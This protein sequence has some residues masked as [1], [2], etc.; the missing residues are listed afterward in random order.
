MVITQ[1]YSEIYKIVKTLQPIKCLSFENIHCVIRL[2]IL[3][4]NLWLSPY[5]AWKWRTICDRKIH[6]DCTRCSNLTTD[7]S[8]RNKNHSRKPS[9]PSKWHHF[10]RCSYIKPIA[11]RSYLF[12]D[13][14]QHSKVDIRKY[15]YSTAPRSFQITTSQFIARSI[16]QNVGLL[17]GEILQCRPSF[18]PLPLWTLL[19]RIQWWKR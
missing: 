16:T 19:R 2:F 9:F 12:C 15:D 13:C 7:F 8:A 17:F 6:T 1:H 4:C 11:T 14:L 3:G 18:H 5:N 10:Q